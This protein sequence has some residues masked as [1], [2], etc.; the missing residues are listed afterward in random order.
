MALN[1]LILSGVAALTALFS[2]APSAQAGVFNIPH[3]VLPGRFALGIE[4]ELTLTSGAGLGVNA[5]YTHGINDLMNAYGI[6]GTGGGPRQFRFGGGV[7]LDFFPDFEGQPGIGVAGQAV[8]YRLGGDVGQLQLTAIP[9]IHKS[10]L[11]GQ[12]KNEVEPFIAFPLGVGLTSGDTIGLANVVVGSLF[13]TMEKIHYVLE[14]GIAVNN[15]E[16]YVSGG[17]AYYY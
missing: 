14:L 9:Y 12:D 13:R 10:F 3:F 5:R 16:T 7:T 15:T 8:Y 6:L 1:R 17:I 2:V 11:T 4:P